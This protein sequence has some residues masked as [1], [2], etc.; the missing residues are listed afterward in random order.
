MVKSFFM[1]NNYY[2][3]RFDLYVHGNG[4]YYLLFMKIFVVGKFIYWGTP[5]LFTIF[6][7]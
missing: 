7:P 1:V 3:Q 6:I 4:R 5:S 2:D